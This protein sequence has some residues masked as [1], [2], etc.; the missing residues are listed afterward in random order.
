MYFRY[1]SKFRLEESLETTRRLHRFNIRVFICIADLYSI[2]NW[3][4]QM[5]VYEFTLSL[6]LI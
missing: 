1:E 2:E 5:Q 6:S 4:L 3:N